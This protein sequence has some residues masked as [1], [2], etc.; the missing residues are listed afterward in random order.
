MTKEWTEY[1]A[2]PVMRR[3]TVVEYINRN[4]DTPIVRRGEAG[5]I[6]WHWVARWRIPANASE[7]NF[8]PVKYMSREEFE[9]KYPRTQLDAKSTPE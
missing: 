4:D 3:D 2:Q 9:K 8:M 1:T 6:C 5:D 7:R